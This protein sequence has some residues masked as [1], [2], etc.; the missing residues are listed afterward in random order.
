MILQ[1]ASPSIIDGATP[2]PRLRASNVAKDSSSTVDMPTMDGTGRQESAECPKIVSAVLKALRGDWEDVETL[3]RLA[4][5]VPQCKACGERIAGLD[6]FV[7]FMTQPLPPH[8]ETSGPLASNR[9][10]HRRL[11]TNEAVN[12]VLPDGNV[13]L[14]RMVEVSA[15]GAKLETP[16]ALQRDV[17]F[18]LNRGRRSIPATVRHCRP[19]GGLFLVGVEYTRQATYA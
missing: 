5:H 3:D 2:P 10:M 11:A 18:T 19:E 4:S 9:R 15:K 14:A 13:I 17:S 1:A 7:K 8:A 12:L 16:E 6:R